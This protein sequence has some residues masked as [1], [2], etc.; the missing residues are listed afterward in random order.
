MHAL[1]F[2]VREA[3]TPED[4]TMLC[5]TRSQCYSRHD[6]EPELCHRFRT[7]EEFD[8]RAV[9]LMAIS[10]A[11]GECLGTIRVNFSTTGPMP[12]C[13][14]EN[15]SELGAQPFAYVDRFAVKRVRGHI[16]VR[17]ALMKAMWLLVSGRQ[18]P[19][20]VACAMAPLAR[21]YRGV[22]LRALVGAEAGIANPKLHPTE[23]Y[24]VVGDKTDVLLDNMREWNPPLAPFFEGMNHPDICY[25]QLA[26]VRVNHPMAA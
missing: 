19:W 12:M 1:P 8:H 17:L 18:V 3:R 10:K 22:G 23:L 20:V 4:L 6:Y 5:L 16:D 11:S 21:L 24:F 7:P 2:L 15:V 13:E 25:P 26:R 14:D 9:V